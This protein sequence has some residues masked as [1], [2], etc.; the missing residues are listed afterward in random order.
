MIK[1]SG[2]GIEEIRSL[3]GNERLLIGTSEIIKSL[4]DNKLDTVYASSNCNE[5]TFKDL[6]R[7]C[8]LSGTE[9]IKLSIP[10]DELGIICKKPFSIAVLGIKKQ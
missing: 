1:K 8:K 3:L 2:K 9:L 4:R 7:Y 6:E 5:T 10:N